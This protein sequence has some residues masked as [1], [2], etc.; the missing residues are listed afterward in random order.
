MRV[1]HIS[2]NDIS[3]N[4]VL[5]DS[6]TF[7]GL[8]RLLYNWAEH[9]ISPMNQIK[10]IIQQNLHLQ[11]TLQRGSLSVVKRGRSW[12]YRGAERPKMD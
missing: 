7:Y 9:L 8:Y 5:H 4:L 11:D 6:R 3:T 2:L 10:F 12:R 1:L